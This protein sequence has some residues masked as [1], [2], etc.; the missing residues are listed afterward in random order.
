MV[1]SKYYGRVKVGRVA[2]GPRFF[3]YTLKMEDF[4]GVDATVDFIEI[5]NK[6][7][8]ILNSRSINTI[9]ENK[10]LCQENIQSIVEFT[11]MFTQHVQEFK[12][13]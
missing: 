6:S 5:F 1:G 10:A 2:N 8:D 4:T 12:I 11:K 3:K 9:N 13:K 7:F